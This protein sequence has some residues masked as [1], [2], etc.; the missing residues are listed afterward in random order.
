MMEKH[1]DIYIITFLTKMKEIK[2]TIYNFAFEDIDSED[3]YLLSKDEAVKIWELNID[4]NDLHFFKLKDGNWL[5]S[6]ERIIIEQNYIVDFNDEYSTRITSELEYLEWKDMDKVFFC[7]NSDL[8]ICTS[9]EIFKRNW[10][11]FLYVYDDCPIILRV[12]ENSSK[13]ALVFNAIGT[14]YRVK[15]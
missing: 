11:N 9:W 8:I 6:N 14:I 12:D 15:G 2:K 1:K 3:I 13:E 5:I 10:I 4:K 7:L